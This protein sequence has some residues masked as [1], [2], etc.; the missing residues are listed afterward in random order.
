MVVLKIIDNEYNVFYFQFFFKGEEGQRKFEKTTDIKLAK[1]FKDKKEMEDT[2]EW[3]TKNNKNC[4]Y[5]WF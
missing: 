4:T 2:L 5:A 1:R 3:L